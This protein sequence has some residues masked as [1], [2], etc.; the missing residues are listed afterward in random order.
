[1]E[2][3]NFT[4]LAALG[5]INQIQ[6]TRCALLLWNRCGGKQAHKIQIPGC[7]HAVAISIRLAKVISRVQKQYRDIWKPTAIEIQKHHVLG[8]KTGSDAE[9]AKFFLK[10]A[11]NNT[12]GGLMLL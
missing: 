1:H 5:G 7:R 8:L 9:S 11:M 12:L 2:R 6:Q 10:H 4:R 3:P